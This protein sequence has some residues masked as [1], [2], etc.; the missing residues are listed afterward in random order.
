MATINGTTGNDLINGTTGNDSIL[1]SWGVDTLYGN[2]GNDSLSGEDNNDY[3]YGNSGNDYL[4]GGSGDDLLYGGHGRDTLFG[5]YGFDRIYGGTG[6]DTIISG[7]DD[8][9]DVL[10][11]NGGADTFDISGNMAYHIFDGTYS[12]REIITDFEVGVDV[13]DIPDQYLG[14]SGFYWG[15]SSDYAY[16]QY[17][18]DTIVELEDV[19]VH[20]ARTIDFV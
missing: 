7:Y 5:G 16:L 9:N 2:S 17:N 20:A 13:L 15:G 19:S 6:N 11:G 1:G 10:T 12:P 14:S 3:L 18:G 8:S 4:S